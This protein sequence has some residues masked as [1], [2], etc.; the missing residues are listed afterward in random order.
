[1]CIINI[2][3]Y[4]TY[5]IDVLNYVECIIYLLIYMYIPSETN[6]PIKN[7]HYEYY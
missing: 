5:L 1:M 7:E 2:I 6:F 4:I 3:Y